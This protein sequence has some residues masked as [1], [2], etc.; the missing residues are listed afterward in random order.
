MYNCIPWNA[1][2]DGNMK[3]RLTLLGKTTI[4]LSICYQQMSVKINRLLEEQN[5]NMTQMSILSHFSHQPH[6]TMNLTSLAKAMGF[7]QPVTTKAVKSLVKSGYLSRMR[8]E[9]DARVLL[10]QVTPLGLSALHE[11]QKNTVP[12]LETLYATQT[13]DQ[14]EHFYESLRKVNIELGKG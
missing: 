6:L 1:C 10:I 8:E 12:L 13:D 2:Q 4:N 11:A 14:L 9:N 5:L 3:D 7:N